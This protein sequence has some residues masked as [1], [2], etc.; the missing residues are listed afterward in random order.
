M[1]K[2]LFY[3]LVKYDK[4]IKEYH[5]I[6]NVP[7]CWNT[8]KVKVSVVIIPYNTATLKRYAFFIVKTTSHTER[9]GREGGLPDIITS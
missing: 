7:W 9:K 1:H 8:S 5:I 6:S 4:L 3:H 2:L